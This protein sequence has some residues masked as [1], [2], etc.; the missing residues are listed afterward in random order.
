MACLFVC[1]FVW[2]GYA[3]E[4]RRGEADGVVGEIESSIDRSVYL[5]INE[6]NQLDF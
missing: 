5:S 2:F 6:R 4:E 1:L 3:W